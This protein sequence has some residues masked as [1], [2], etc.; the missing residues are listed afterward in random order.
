MSVKNKDA[1]GSICL[2]W[3]GRKNED[4]ASQLMQG[5][6]RERDDF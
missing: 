1:L 2:S 3:R 6:Q 4:R 5:L